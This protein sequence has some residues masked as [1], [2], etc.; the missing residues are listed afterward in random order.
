MVFERYGC[1]Q[2]SLKGYNPRKHS[3]PSRHPQLVILAE[4]TL[5]GAWIASSS[6]LQV[7]VDAVN[8]RR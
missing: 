8:L 5:S 7:A 2:G 1:Q 3:R 6:N 4:A